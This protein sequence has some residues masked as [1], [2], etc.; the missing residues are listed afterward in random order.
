MTGL[1]EDMAARS[2]ARHACV[3]L[4]LLLLV[5]LLPA[6]ASAETTGQTGTV[7]AAATTNSTARSET[8]VGQTETSQVTPARGSTGSPGGG[9]AYLPS[10]GNGGYDVLGYDITLD[11]DPGTGRIAARTVV[12]AMALEDLSAFSLDLV[13][14]D[15]SSVLVDGS[16]ASFKRDGQDLKI[17]C[18]QVIE[19]TKQFSVQVSY[20]G[21]PKGLDHDRGWHE[22]NGTIYTFDEP[23]GAACWFPVNDTPADKAT[24]V[25]RISVP[26][27]YTAVATGMLVTTESQGDRQTFVWEM[28]DPMASYLAGVDIGSFVSDTSTSSSGVPIRNYYDVNVA[29]KARQA[30]AREGE[31]ID[32]FSTLFGPYPFQA[33]GVVA[34]NVD[35]EA[36]MENQTLILFGRNK[37]DSGMGFL[38]HELAHQWFGDS[39]T[40][41]R[42]K[43]IWLNEGFATYASWLWYEHTDG[44][45]GLQAE[46][47]RAEK[48]LGT[49]PGQILT[50][51]GTGSLFA[52]FVYSKGALT[53]HALRLEVGDE[54]FFRTMRAW[55]DRHKFGNVSTSDFIALAKEEAPQVPATDLDS[56][57]DKW[58]NQPGL[59]SLPA[60]RAP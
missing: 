18:P 39:V 32:Y 42:W 52:D 24:Y 19:S 25:F 9:D 27:P 37:L 55:A 45:P 1:R 38:A 48:E 41:S 16:A 30:F 46:V 5:L 59:P 20:S 34:L 21:V 15:V 40:I 8:T 3:A 35:I 44:W 33:C 11:V 4:T 2:I 57:F 10:A 12:N 23:E 26:K 49:S 50:D 29:D 22:A 17:A 60:S 28:K 47:E 58:L 56:L 31:V 7:P 13:G 36:A 54:S 53:L 6:C 43:D 51:P 14:L